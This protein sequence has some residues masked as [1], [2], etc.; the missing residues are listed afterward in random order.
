MFSSLSASSD[1]LFFS[2]FSFFF[3]VVD[4]MV[5]FFFHAVTEPLT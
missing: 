1:G 4:G 2:P 5:L 3:F